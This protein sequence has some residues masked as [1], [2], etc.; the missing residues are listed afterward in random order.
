MHVIAAKAVAFGEALTPEFKTYQEQ[1][2]KNASALAAALQ[3]LGFRLVAGGTDN[4]LMLVDVGAGGLTGK[5]VANALDKASIT[6]NKNGIPFDQKSPFVTSGVR[7]GTPAVTTRGM[8]EEEMKTIAG[9]IK[10][11]TE[12]MG[13]E[14]E[15][16]TI[17]KEVVAFA[18]R[19]ILP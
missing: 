11:V 12:N 7:L 15:L 16:E 3:E 5:D 13:D 4:H 14:A 1:V 9:F 6:A 8:K 19:F 18:N 17:R 2:V 10:A